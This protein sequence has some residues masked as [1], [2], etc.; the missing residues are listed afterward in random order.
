MEKRLHRNIR[1]HAFKLNRYIHYFFRLPLSE[2]HLFLPTIMPHLGEVRGYEYPL[3]LFI[4]IDFVTSET[5]ER[6]V[7]EAKLNPVV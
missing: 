6:A 2:H 5:K 3:P 1:A 4:I 7:P